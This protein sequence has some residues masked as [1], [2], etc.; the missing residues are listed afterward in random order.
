MAVLRLIVGRGLTEYVIRK[1]EEAFMIDATVG[2]AC[3]NAGIGHTAYYDEINRNPEFADKMDRAQQ[4]PFLGHPAHGRAA[5]AAHR[6]PGC[7]PPRRSPLAVL[8]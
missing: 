2:E 6:D 3:A 8:Q 5:R 1:L 7:D 4:F